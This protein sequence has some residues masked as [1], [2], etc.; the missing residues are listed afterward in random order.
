MCLK[1]LLLLNYT[2]G[3][4]TSEMAIALK[5][6]TFHS[7][8]LSSGVHGGSESRH[9]EPDLVAQICNFIQPRA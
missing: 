5:R 8:P 6:H 4:H 2:E 3:L 7:F 1:S 9:K